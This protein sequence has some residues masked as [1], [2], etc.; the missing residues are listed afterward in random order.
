MVYYVF[1]SK[2][3]LPYSNNTTG[4]NKWSYH[5]SASA[6]RYILGLKYCYITYIA[7]T[8]LSFAIRAYFHYMYTFIS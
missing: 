6:H 4:L 7:K 8:L 3:Q 2:L 5:C 1:N